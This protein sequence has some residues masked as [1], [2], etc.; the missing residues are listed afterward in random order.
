MSLAWL[1]T[2]ECCNLKTTEWIR[3]LASL[4]ERHYKEV[5]ANHSKLCCYA[6]TMP[7][8]HLSLQATGRTQSGKDETDYIRSPCTC[9]CICLYLCECCTCVYSLCN[10]TV[11]QSR[12]AWSPAKCYEKLTLNSCLCMCGHVTIWA[13]SLRQFYFYTHRLKNK[14]IACGAC[15]L[16]EL[17]V[18]TDI[19]KKKNHYRAHTCTIPTSRLQN[20]I[21]YSSCDWKMP[22]CNESNSG[23][24]RKRRRTS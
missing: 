7:I 14:N 19:S 13:P 17:S 6:S 8:P 22:D 4:W 24:G 11:G 15:G 23:R 16:F 20:A 1:Y 18:N 2:A 5:G 21:N 9:T 10:S 12:T 3:H